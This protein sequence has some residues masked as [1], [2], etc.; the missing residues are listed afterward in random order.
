MIARISF[1]L[2]QSLEVIARISFQLPQSLEVI[3]RISF[4][5]PQSL[6]V[7]ARISFGLPQSRARFLGLSHWIGFVLYLFVT[8]RPPFSSP[9]N[10][11][12]PQYLR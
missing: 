11:N 3:D 1:Q 5:L 4:G 12:P 2:P 8:N 7:V 6:E 10:L 9:L